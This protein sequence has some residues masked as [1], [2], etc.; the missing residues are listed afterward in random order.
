[1]K[2]STTKKNGV[3]AKSTAMNVASMYV[4][5][6][7]FKPASLITHAVAKNLHHGYLDN[8]LPNLLTEAGNKLRGFNISKKDLADIA[9]AGVDGGARIYLGFDT[10][11]RLY[12]LLLVAIDVDGANVTTKI[13]DDFLPCP[14][15]CPCEADGEPDPLKKKKIFES[16]LNYIATIG[17][18]VEFKE[19]NRTTKRKRWQ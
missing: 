19:F 11:T 3:K 5:Q 7:T 18:E 9:A 14:D 1:M 10:A 12:K 6:S 4:F 2:T 15:T 17:D 16:D 13:V 8:P